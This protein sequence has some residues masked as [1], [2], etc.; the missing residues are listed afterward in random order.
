MCARS[1]VLSRPPST[2][3]AAPNAGWPPL[4]PDELTY[5]TM[6]SKVHSSPLPA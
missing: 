4:L 5:A 1:G 2:P 3:S 6:L